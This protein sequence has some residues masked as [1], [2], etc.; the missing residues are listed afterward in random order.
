MVLKRVGE[1]PLY[2]VQVSV[3]YTTG[4][5]SRLSDQPL[6]S[7]GEELS[8]ASA[9]KALEGGNLDNYSLGNIVPSF[10][11][12]LVRER[13]LL[14]GKAVHHFRIHIV[15]RNGFWIQA[16]EMK[17]GAGDN[18]SWLA[19]YRVEHHARLG[20]PIDPPVVLLTH[21]PENYDGQPSW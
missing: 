8:L 21:V 19:A 10:E 9:R 1:F 12:E 20:Q 11:P 18:S 4:L 15:A 16:V 17:R 13:K 7:P 3:Q 2:D 14:P 5:I 6:F